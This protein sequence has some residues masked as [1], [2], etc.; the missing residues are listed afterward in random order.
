[1]ED[2]ERIPVYYPVWMKLLS[3]VGLPALTLVALWLISRPIWEEGLT[4]SQFLIGAALGCAVLYQCI[5]GFFV[6]KYINM[7]IVVLGEGLEVHFRNSVRFIP[8]EHIG[9]I[10]EYSFATTTQLIERNGNTLIYAFDNMK[11]F[12][13]IKCTLNELHGY[14]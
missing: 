13:V 5:L 4:E 8:W 10:K 2:E 14:G 12:S 9:R 7:R 6:L 11:N 1:M 3:W